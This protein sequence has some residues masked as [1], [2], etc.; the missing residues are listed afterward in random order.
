MDINTIIS[1]RIKREIVSLIIRTI[2]HS[3]AC[4]LSFWAWW[5]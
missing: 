1:I 3:F 4:R 2:I 5:W